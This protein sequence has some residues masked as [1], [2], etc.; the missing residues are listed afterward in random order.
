M[1]AQTPSSAAGNTFSQAGKAA[2]KITQNAETRYEATKEKVG[3]ALD[4]GR[5][6][7]TDSAQAAGDSLS[8]DMA[9]LREDMTAIQQTLSKFASEAG[10]EAMKAAQSVGATVASQVSGAASD[11]AAGAKDVAASAAESAKTFASELEGMARRNPL[12]TIGAT[13]LVGVVIGMMSRSRS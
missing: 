10:G 3:D 9:K 11:V 6:G 5:S 12:G 7:I 13:L 1:N 4:R 2:D 8:Q